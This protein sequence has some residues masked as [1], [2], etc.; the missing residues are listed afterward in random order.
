[1]KPLIPFRSYDPDTSRILARLRNADNEFNKKE[2]AVRSHC[3]Q[4][5]RRYR[6]RELE[7]VRAYE[8]KLLLE[9]IREIGEWKKEHQLAEERRVSEVV[10]SVLGRFLRDDVES[11]IPHIV[12]ETQTMVHQQPAHQIIAL[13]VSSQLE[14]P[15]KS[16]FPH[17]D[18]IADS[19]LKGG[20]VLIQTSTGE[21]EY[22]WERHL[23]T[24]LD[25]L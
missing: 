7:R 6:K 23:Q 15:L 8:A 10:R 16:A 25:F 5:L 20:S 12:R 14:V 19:E 3:A 24:I 11:K 9:V 13:R 22:S 21:M 17:I 18:V 4:L 2:K 1:M